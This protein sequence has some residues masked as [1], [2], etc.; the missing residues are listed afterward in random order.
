MAARGILNDNPGN[1]RLSNDKWQGLRPIQTDTEFFQFLD[2]SWGIRA[3]AVVLIGY[4][5]KENL[6]TITDVINRYA[7]PSENN[8][9]SYVADVSRYAVMTPTAKLNLHNYKDIMPLI[10]AIIYHENGEQPYSDST[11]NQGLARAGILI[12][13]T[14]LYATKVI[15]G[16]TIAVAGSASGIGGTILDNTPALAEYT[17]ASHWSHVVCAVLTSLGISLSIFGKVKD[18]AKSVTDGGS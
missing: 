5:D 18:H 10:K 14:P 3:M 16:A 12:P 2:P 6:D 15:Q 9:N 4:Y 11:I 17:G 1:L 7:P 13:K 8:T